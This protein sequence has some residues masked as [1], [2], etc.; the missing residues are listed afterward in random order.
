MRKRLFAVGLA[1][2]LS[3]TAT[4]AAVASR[5]VTP[6][7]AHAKALFCEDFQAL[8]LGGASSLNWGVDTK[9]GTLTVERDGRRGQKVLHVH[10]EGNGRAFLKVDDFAAPG[11]S[12]FGRVR[13][14]V[15][16]FP[17]APDWAHYTVIEATGAGPEI[18][19]PLGGQYVP[20]VGDGVALWGVGADGG[21]TGDWTNWR[22]SAPSKAG[23]WTCV[24]WR[25]DAADNRISVWLDGV[26]KPDLTV[27][28]KSHGGNDVDFV[29]PQFNTV[30]LGWQLYQG[31]PTPSSYDLWLDDIQL[32][33]KRVGC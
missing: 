17:T 10:T 5:P 7:C 23:V 19:R 20:V 3:I 15:A 4:S 1:V 6:G 29:F 2:L 13:L 22:E 14:R 9:H 25:M 33:S 21:P 16:A 26:A 27:S 8:P 28:T 31:G 30:K 11:N 24:E 32:S 12:F 18:V